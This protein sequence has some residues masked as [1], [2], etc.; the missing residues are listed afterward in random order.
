MR[1]LAALFGIMA[2]GSMAAQADDGT[3][4]EIVITA[5]RVPTLEQRIPAGVTVIDR[6]TIEDRGYNTLADALS[7]VP[8]LK[9][10]A[11]GGPG[12]PASAFVRGSNS[13]HVLVLRDGMPINDAADSAGAFNFGVDTLSDVDRI[14]I[15]RGPM[16]ALYGSGAIGGVINLIS[17]QGR[18]AG[19]HWFGDVAGGYPM[20]ARG[21][22]G[23]TGVS[24]DFD[25]AATAES[26]SQRGYDST[27]QRMAIYTGVPTGFRDRIGTLNLGYTPVDGTRLSL[28]L[29]ARQ[30]LFGFNA[31]GAPTFDDS[32]SDGHAASLLGRVGLT[33]HLFDGMW[34][35]GLFAGRLQEDRAYIEALNQLDPNLTA[36]DSRYHAYRTDVQWN[37]TVHLAGSALTFGFQHTADTIRLRINDNFGG[38]PFAQNAAASMN[39]DGA[40]AGVQTTLWEHLTLTAQARQDWVAGSAPATW[41][42]GS[43]LEVPSLATRFKA[44]YGNAFRAPSL[45]DRFGVDSYG[46]VGNPSLKPETAQGWDAGFVTDPAPWVSFGATYFNQQVQNLIE[47]VFA[48][49]DTAINIGSAHMQG[50][51]TELTVR[52]AHWLTLHATYSFTDTTAIGQPSAAGSRLLRRPPNAAS[53]DARITPLPGLRIV[54]RLTYTGA[55]EDYLYDNT[56]NPAGYGVGQQG[57]LANLT[58]TY[59]VQPGVQ[60]YTAATNIL[61]SR[62]EPVNGYQTPGPGVVLGV[63][64]QL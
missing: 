7:D 40:H 21:T 5:T 25:Y 27:P 29:R 38:F 54:P 51:E 10:S 56:G 60:V 31:L 9:L 37:N 18:E 55:A 26:Q 35:T 36:T 63:R 11:S 61:A 50:V 43:V 19:P 34:E 12:G 64:L 2:C 30:A 42:V 46:Y 33:S 28:L 45:F 44:A 4:H 1:R 57:W 53:F 41:R 62:F 59:D 49:V 58:V 6:R 3:L 8:G 24:G 13:N 52:P 20:Q 14:E 32:N 48:P 15:V 47:A 17:R 16:A 39:A 22:V 23:V